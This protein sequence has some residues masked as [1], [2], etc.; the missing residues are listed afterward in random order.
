MKN[1]GI[2]EEREDEISIDGRSEEMQGTLQEKPQTITLFIFSGE[3]KH[4]DTLQTQIQLRKYDIMERYSGDEI[5]GVLSHMREVSL[6][7]LEKMVQRLM[8]ITRFPKVKCLLMPIHF[9]KDIQRDLLG[10][11]KVTLKEVKEGE[12]KTLSI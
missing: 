7:E 6:L 10:L 8:E 9:Q 12:V 3:E 1:L 5:R 11:L 4:L 2:L